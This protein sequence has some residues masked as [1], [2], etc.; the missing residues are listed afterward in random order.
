M[1]SHE[2]LG[3]LFD[4]NAEFTISEHFRPHWAQAGSV[5]FITFRTVDSI[6]H[7]VVQRWDHEKTEWLKA[8]NYPYD[9]HWSKIIPKLDGPSRIRFHRHFDR[10]REIFLDTCQGECLFK[11]TALAQI[12][13]DSLMHF[14]GDRYQMGDFVV[15]PN[16]V[17]LLASFKSEEMIVTQCDSWMHYTARQI[18]LRTG[19]KGKLWQQEPFD[20]LV[21]NLTQYECLRTYIRENGPSANLSEGAYLYRRRNDS[22]SNSK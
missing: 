20:H 6:P 3:D 5:V 4:P 13:A 8:N 17:H 19:R 10:C 15:M 22:S 12:V 9:A 11:T 7:E 16:H 2:P 18:N 1:T 21:R 14:D